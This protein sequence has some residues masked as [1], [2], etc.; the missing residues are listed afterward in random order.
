MEAYPN[1]S[2]DVVNFRYR[3]T[4]KTKVTIRI[5]DTNGKVVAV[6]VNNELRD[7]DTYELKWSSLSSGVYY[8]VLQNNGSTVQ[9]I[10]V[11]I[12]K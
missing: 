1:P 2:F 8:A 7:A 10:K 3:V 6:P 9:S 12:A 5:Y 11:T 4:T